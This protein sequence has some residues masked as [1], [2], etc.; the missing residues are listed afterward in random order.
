VQWI[1]YLGYVLVICFGFVIAF[2]APYLPTL[3]RQ[4]RVALSMIDLKPGETLLELGSGDG[5]VVKLAAQAGIKVVGYELNPVLV[6]VSRLRTWRYR[7]QVKIV[8]GNFWR[9]EKWPEADGIF[10]FLLQKYMIKLDK[11]IV[12]LH[13]EQRRPI[14]LV[15]FAFTVP[16]KTPIKETKGLYLYEYR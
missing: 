16:S 9:N 2:G 1:W 13:E 6:L 11:K 4:A 5:R 8:W 12:Q 15:S 7:K 10:V 14:K 3:N